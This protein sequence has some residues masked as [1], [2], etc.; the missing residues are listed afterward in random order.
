MLNPVKSYSFNFT[1]DGQTDT[2]EIDLSLLP[3]GEDF[4]GRQPMA[5][6]SPV[7]TGAGAIVQGVTAE[8][9]GTTV[10]LTFPNPPNQYDANDNLIV[11]TATFYLQYGD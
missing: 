5:V 4:A 6:L 7:V 2:L 3:I 8:L 11:Y 10:T 1:A 9:E